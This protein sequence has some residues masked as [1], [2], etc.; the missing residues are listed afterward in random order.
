VSDAPL[1]SVVVP[2]IGRPGKLLPL[3]EG[4]GRQTLPRER[5][6]IVVV[7]DGVPPP[8]DATAALERASARVVMLAA[9]SGPP[10]ARNAGASAARGAFLVH[11]DDDVTPEPDWLANAAARLA[12]DPALDVIE[13]VTRKPGGR[14]VRIRGDEERQYILCNLIVRRA[15]FERVGGFHTGYYEPATGLF[16]REDADLG[17]S[18]ERIGA[19][20]ARGTDVVVVHPEENPRY[21]DPLRWTQRYVMDALLAARFPREFRDRIEVHRLGGLV[22]RRPIVRA[23]FGFVLGVLIALA[24]LLA[25]QPRIAAAAGILAALCFVPVWAKWRFDPRRLPVFLLVPFGLVWARLRGVP[26][27]RRIHARRAGAQ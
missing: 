4:L 23:S 19:N 2:T 15:M 25:R 10:I 26:R 5:F 17:W 13:G 14:A 22:V 12:A 27:A 24:A 18:L 11:T 9:R 16:F 1:F 7:F 3:L 20:V 8:P 21:A 6:E